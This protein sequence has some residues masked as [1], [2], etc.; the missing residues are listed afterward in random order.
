MKAFYHFSKKKKP[1]ALP[2]RRW[3]QP[4]NYEVRNSSVIAP[5]A[6]TYC[7]ESAQ[8]AS[9]HPYHWNII[10]YIQ[11]NLPGLSICSGKQWDFYSLSGWKPRPINRPAHVTSAT[12]RDR[13]ADANCGWKSW[14]SRNSWLRSQD[15]RT[16]HMDYDTDHLHIVLSLLFVMIQFNM[17]ASPRG[18]TG[19]VVRGRRRELVLHD[20]P[21]WLVT[22]MN[23]NPTHLSGNES[24]R[25]SATDESRL[26]S[27]VID[28]S[29]RLRRCQELF[30]GPW[31]NLYP[32]L[33]G[34]SGGRATKSWLQEWI[35]TL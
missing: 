16:S 2:R 34:E 17:V 3:S 19:I 13:G 20:A 30:R 15:W 9:V 28:I 32:S 5:G 4:G 22:G 24:K 18:S 33:K 26:L 8:G 31:G 1:G 14:F 35:E 21:K 10:Q 25:S 23:L 27:F 7:L 12:P 29:K 6:I 11:I